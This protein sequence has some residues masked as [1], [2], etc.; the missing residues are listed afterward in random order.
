MSSGFALFLAFHGLLRPFEVLALRGNDLLPPSECSSSG[1]IR[2][3]FG[4]TGAN[5]FSRIMEPTVL[6]VLQ[7]L[8]YAHPGEERTFGDLNY[9]IYKADL[10]WACRAMSLPVEFTPHSARHGGATARFLAGDSP[11]VIRLAGRWSQMKSM[12]TYLQGHSCLHLTLHPPPQ[13]GWMF[14]TSLLLRSR[15]LSLV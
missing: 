15:L 7:Y 10:K 12:E 14:T 11:D 5:Q 1:G 13:F 9:S 6:R 2:I 8:K 4:K 3:R